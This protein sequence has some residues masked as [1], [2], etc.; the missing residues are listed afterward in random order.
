MAERD[1]L[2]WDRDGQDWPYR[3]A[4][5]FV[6][7]SGYRWHVQLLGPKTAPVFLLIHGT[8]AA[9]FSW[10]NLIPLL[11]DQYQ[12]VVLDLP[13]HG[14][15]RPTASP[16]LSLEGM[17]TSIR[18]L[19]HHLGLRPTLL[20]GHSAGAVITVSL[21]NAARMEKQDGNHT[22][23]FSVNG[24]L[25]PI[26]GNRLLSPMAK[27]LFA[28]PLSASMFSL[29]AKTTPLGNNLLSATGSR[30]DPLGNALYQRLLSSSGHVRGALGMMAS[31]DLSHLNAMLK[32]LA[33]PIDFYAAE[34]DPM[35]PA[36]S[37]KKAAGYA[38]NSRLTLTSNG[39]HLVHESHPE[40]VAEWIEAALQ[41]RNTNGADAA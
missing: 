39:G 16:D 18:G 41:S 9:S 35:V 15:T 13:C 12:L 25:K 23:V 4:S 20:L 7:V 10:H 28:N 6:T 33:V 37:S 36:S 40:L 34:D 29:L 3:D 24:A 30:I 14:F 31:W 8:G 1:W 38:P 5:T 21:M 22:H 27:A 11:M 26:R 19:L 2:D 32:R 17:T